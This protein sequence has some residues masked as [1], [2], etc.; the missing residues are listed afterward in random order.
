MV[1]STNNINNNS[2]WNIEKTNLLTNFKPKNNINLEL[3]ECSKVK[4]TFVQNYQCNE[5]FRPGI[6]SKN[7]FKFKI[8]Y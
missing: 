2:R 8:K 4:E 5:S 7:Y 3:M 1:I 6:F